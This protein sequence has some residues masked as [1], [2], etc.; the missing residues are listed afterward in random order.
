MNPSVI[1]Q[2]DSVPN[3]LTFI[4]SSGQ[5]RIILIYGQSMVIFCKGA[6]INFPIGGKCDNICVKIGMKGSL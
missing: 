3:I 6:T 1:P 4:F 5:T 2:D